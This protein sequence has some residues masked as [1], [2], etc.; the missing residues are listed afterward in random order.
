M[1][2]DNPVNKMVTTKTLKKYGRIVKPAGNG[3][4]A[5]EQ[6]KARQFDL[7]LMDCNMPEMDG[8]EATGHIRTYEEFTDRPRTTI[9]AF[10]ANAMKEDEIACREAGMDDFPTKPIQA[11]ALEAILRKWLRQEY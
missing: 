8:L 6:A 1:A 5:L 7:I 11:D 2:E 3:K 4:E 10:T 9:I